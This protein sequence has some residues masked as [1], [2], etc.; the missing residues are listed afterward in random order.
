MGRKKH[1]KSSP[2]RHNRISFERNCMVGE[3]MNAIMAVFSSEKGYEAVRLAIRYILTESK[4]QMPVPLWKK[5]AAVLALS[6]IKDFFG[7]LGMGENLDRVMLELVNPDRINDGD[8]IVS[9]QKAANDWAAQNHV[10]S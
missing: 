4:R 8:R 6:D 2:R 5:T 3:V 9:L 1:C 10:G 7:G